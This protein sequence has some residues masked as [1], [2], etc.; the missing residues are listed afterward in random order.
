MEP[1]PSQDYV[2]KNDE[3]DD[4]ACLEGMDEYFCNEEDDEICN[5]AMDEIER[6]SGRGFLFEFHPY[7]D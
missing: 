1:Q 7:T 4:E 6:Q 2:M 5:Q 3:T